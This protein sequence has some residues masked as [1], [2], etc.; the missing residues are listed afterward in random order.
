MRS[1]VEGEG[2][3][4]PPSPSQTRIHRV[5]S[6]GSSVPLVLIRGL[7]TQAPRV[8]VGVGVEVVGVVGIVSTAGTRITELPPPSVSQGIEGPGGKRLAWELCIL[9]R[10]S[11]RIQVC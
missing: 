4:L 7:W 2:G 6:Y 1:K 9:L 11:R 8:G 5:V 10:H 3:A